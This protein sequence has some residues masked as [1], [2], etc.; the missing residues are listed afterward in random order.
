MDEPD[1]G[2]GGVL[3]LATLTP[4]TEGLD[5]ALGEEILVPLR[6]VDHIVGIL[7]HD[8]CIY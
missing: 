3:V 7:R 8:H 6:N 5:A 1:S 2:F 4:G